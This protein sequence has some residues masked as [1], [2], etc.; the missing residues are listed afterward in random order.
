MFQNQQL[1]LANPPVKKQNTLEMK[2]SRLQYSRILQK[3]QSLTSMDDST[4]DVVNLNIDSGSGGY[5]HKTQFFFLHK[6]YISL[7]HCYA[8]FFITTFF[9]FIFFYES[10]FSHLI[11][12][13]HP[14]VIA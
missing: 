7:P 8:R 13:K 1:T 14:L 3:M 10:I 5:K 9:Y 6:H 2:R 4:F 11:E 12:I